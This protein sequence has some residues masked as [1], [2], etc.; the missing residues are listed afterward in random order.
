MALKR[1]IFNNKLIFV[2]Q[3]CAIAEKKFIDAIEEFLCWAKRV[4]YYTLHPE[5]PS[6]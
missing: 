3:D 5:L 1:I 2:L 4:R 6:G